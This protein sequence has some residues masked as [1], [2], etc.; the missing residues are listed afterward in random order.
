MHSE[1]H[2]FTGGFADPVLSSQSVFRALMDGMASPARVLSLEDKAEVPQP[3]SPAMAAVAL[4]LLDHDTQVW[5]SPALAAS[6]F[7]QWLAFYAGA[8]ITADRMAADFAFFTGED[9]FPELS[10]LPLGSDTYPDRS[11]TLVIEVDALEGGDI[12]IARGP[13]IREVQE[14]SPMGLSA[15]FLSEWEIN[16]GLYPRGL[17]IILV[18]G[19]AFL[20]LPRTTRLVK[21]E[22]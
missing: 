18:S 11:T 22:G 1:T 6:A 9:G 13:G 21:R 15:R 12:L 17:D 3:V 2:V 20:C 14:L 16:R 19:A 10:G 8:P 4:T 7:P 5:L